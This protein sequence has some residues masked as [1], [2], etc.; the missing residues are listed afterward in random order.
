ME[1][2]HCSYFLDKEGSSKKKEQ[3]KARHQYWFKN[4]FPDAGNIAVGNDEMDNFHIADE[5]N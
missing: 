2:T 1:F 3:P 4:I 5:V